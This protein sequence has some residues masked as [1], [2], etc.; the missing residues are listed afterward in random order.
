MNSFIAHWLNPLHIF[1]R[2]KDMGVGNGLARKIGTWYEGHIFN[3]QRRKEIQLNELIVSLKVR[4]KNLTRLINQY[5]NHKE[6]NQ[7][8]RNKLLFQ[9]IL[10]RKIKQQEETR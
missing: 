5:P 4:I 2:L 3:R 6:M 7:W 8:V 9:K 10:A 1:C